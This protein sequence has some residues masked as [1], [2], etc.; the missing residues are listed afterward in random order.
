MEFIPYEEVTDWISSILGFDDQCEVCE[1]DEDSEVRRLE[2]NIQEKSDEELKPVESKK[3]S[4]NLIRNAGV[5]LF[6]GLAIL[7]F[8]LIFYLAKLL[9]QRN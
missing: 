2:G 8:L 3:A 4:S 5:M 1:I 6:I 9:V 7:I